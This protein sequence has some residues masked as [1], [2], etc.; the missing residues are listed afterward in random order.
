MSFWDIVWF[1]LIS[2][3]FIAYLMVM[4]AMITDLFRDP[5]ASG[6][7]KAVWIIALI[8]APFVTAVVY[9]IVR[10]K[11]MGER[12]L[13]TAEAMREQQESYI[14]QVSSQ[15]SPADQIAQAKALLDS[16]A[17]TPEEYERLK[18]KAL[19]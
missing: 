15:S 10:G 2:F 8:V 3:A 9:L 18:D 5:D 7:V 1:I 17:I 16:Q 12:Q 13:R 19:S 11:G 14:R 4:F 6:I